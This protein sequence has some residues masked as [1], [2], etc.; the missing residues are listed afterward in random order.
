MKTQTTL[1][2]AVAAFA[3]SMSLFM[4]ASAADSICQ[5]CEQ[6]Y[7]T[8][9]NIGTLTPAQCLTAWYNCVPSGTPTCPLPR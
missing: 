9:L 1:R 7:Q 2:A 8:C 4:T 6:R 5:R 3:F